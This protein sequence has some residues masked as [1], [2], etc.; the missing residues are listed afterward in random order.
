MVVNI[1]SQGDDGDSLEFIVIFLG[2]A[3]KQLVCG[4][5]GDANFSQYSAGPIKMK[6]TMR[7]TSQK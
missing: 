2:P 3:S 7:I 4:S 1:N 6:I 5:S